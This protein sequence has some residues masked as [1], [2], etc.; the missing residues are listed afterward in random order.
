M[1]AHRKHPAAGTGEHA[2]DEEE[3]SSERGIIYITLW[4][5]RNSGVPQTTLILYLCIIPAPGALRCKS[6]SLCWQPCTA[7]PPALPRVPLSHTTLPQS[8]HDSWLGADLL[9]RT[10][11]PSSCILLPK[12]MEAVSTYTTVAPLL[13]HLFPSCLSFLLSN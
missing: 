10:I 8:L 6:F 4:L 13:P 9:F 7:L 1:C 5:C 11:N 2:H 3:K 12:A